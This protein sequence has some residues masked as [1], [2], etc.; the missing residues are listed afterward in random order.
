M[1]T[2]PKAIEDRIWKCADGLY[3]IDLLEGLNS[4]TGQGEDR[5]TPATR[6]I[7]TRRR[8]DLLSK[9]NRIPYVKATLKPALGDVWVNKGSGGKGHYRTTKIVRLF[10]TYRG[11][12]YKWPIM[13]DR[14]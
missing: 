11:H 13:Y 3:E 9:I 2:L 5:F 4:W 1:L 8:K 10:V 7:H 12:L 14:P 6:K